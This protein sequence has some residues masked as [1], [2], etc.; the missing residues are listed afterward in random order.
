[1][2]SVW[3]RITDPFKR[4]WID[5]IPNA[6]VRDWAE[7]IIWALVIALILRTFVIQAFYIPSGSMIP[8]LMPNDRV[9]VNKFIYRF[10]EPRRGE[11]F[12]F[13]Y[14]ED[15]SKDYVKRL[16]AVPGD[17][18]SIQ[19]GTVFINGKPIDE[20][21]VKYKDSFT[22]PELVV[23]PDSFIALGDNRPNSADSRF[24][25]FVPRANLSGPVMFRF[26][27]LNRFGLVD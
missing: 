3:Q 9:F 4:I 6:R 17:K 22:L 18:F 19:D 24:W 11:I 12:V 20:P 15:P 7:T 16:I 14:P 10:R 26:W 27:P 13:K 1:M 25:G 8:T 21:Y 2:L 5:L 23:P